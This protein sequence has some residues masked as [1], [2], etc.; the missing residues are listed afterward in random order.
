M[1][2]FPFLETS[3]IGLKGLNKRNQHVFQTSLKEIA[4]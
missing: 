3:E 1:A 2:V 4:L